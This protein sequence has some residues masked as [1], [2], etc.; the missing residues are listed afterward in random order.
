MFKTAQTI[1]SAHNQEIWSCAWSK[2]NY[3]ITGSLDETVK[4]WQFNNEGVQQGLYS[5]SQIEHNLAVINVTLANDILATSSMDGHIRLYDLN[6]NEL[7]KIIKL[8][9]FILWSI[10]I[11]PQGKNI[12]TG[13]HNGKISIYNIDQGKVIETLDT[14]D[15]GFIQV[16]K[17]S[18]DGK[19][20]AASNKNGQIFLYDINQSKFLYGNDLS[21]HTR[22]I[23]A[24]EFNH[25][26][27]MLFIGCDDHHITAIDIETGEIKQTITAH[28]SWVLALAFHP[29]G[30]YFA[31][32]GAD[33]CIRI[34]DA[35]TL[36][37]LH[38]FEKLNQSQIWDISFSPNGKQ[39]AAVTSI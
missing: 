6:T 25:D 11:D 14:K 4:I 27:T 2:H 23:R 20:I 19:Y 36:E 18:S 15:N 7:I 16:V 28:K 35:D 13:A 5:N 34:Y 22:P 1:E 26:N 24:I 29:S 10:S 3:I 30:K 17:Y 21:S 39:L 32:A 12:I 9:P 31:S 8:S 38:T 37:V 33:Q